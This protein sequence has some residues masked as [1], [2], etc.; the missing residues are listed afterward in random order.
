MIITWNFYIASYISTRLLYISPRAVIFISYTY[1][2]YQRINNK[3]HVIN[4]YDD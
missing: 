3:H 1:R 4:D 2:K